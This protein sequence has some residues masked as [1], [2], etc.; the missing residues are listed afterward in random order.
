MNEDW[1]DYDEPTFF[2]R[3]ALIIVGL[4]AILGLWTLLALIEQW[5]SP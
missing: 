1:R 4:L 2:D 5:G 3:A